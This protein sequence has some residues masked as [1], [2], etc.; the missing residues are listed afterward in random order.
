MFVHVWICCTTSFRFVEC[1]KY[2]T[3]TATLEL[4]K[5][6]GVIIKNNVTKRISVVWAIACCLN[7][8]IH[9]FVCVCYHNHVERVRKTA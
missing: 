6:E 3:M 8:S 2:K 7:I 1:K 4:D 9:K 5:R